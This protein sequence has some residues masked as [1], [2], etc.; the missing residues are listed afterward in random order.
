LRNWAQWGDG[1]PAKFQ[2][3]SVLLEPEEAERFDAFCR[4]KGFKKSALIARLI[5]EHLQQEQFRTQRTLFE[6]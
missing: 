1:V 6:R 5:R 2:K 4:E 3:V